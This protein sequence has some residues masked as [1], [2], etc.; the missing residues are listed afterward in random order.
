MSALC[1]WAN[2]QEICARII[3]LAGYILPDDK[4]GTLGE[5]NII[6]MLKVNTDTPIMLIHGVNDKE[7]NVVDCH[8]Y[9]RSIF[10]G[11]V[12]ACEEYIFKFYAIPRQGNTLILL[13]LETQPDY[14]FP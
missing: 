8:K 14:G 1:L 7:C 3:I 9:L 11:N 6:R 4:M 12:F 10:S 13:R 2:S 5:S